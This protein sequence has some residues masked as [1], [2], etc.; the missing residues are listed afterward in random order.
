M[1]PAL[2]LFGLIL[3]TAPQPAAAFGDDGH[4]AVALIAEHYLTREARAQVSALLKAD[5]DPLT[6]HD[7]AS[8]ATWADKYRDSNNRRDHYNETR[9]WHFVDLEI[10]DPDLDT[11]CNGRKPLP[12]RTP[13]SAGPANDCVIDKITQFAAELG[14]GGTDAGERLLALKFVLHLVGDLHQPLHAADNNDAGGNRVKVVVEGFEHKSRDALHGFFD[15]QFV[16]ALAR[17]PAALA[18]QLILKITPQQ[19]A[20]WKT[21]SVEDW[22]M[23]AFNVAFTDVYGDPPLS[24]DKVE[25]LDA[26]YVQRAKADVAMQLS[27]AGV[28]LAL[29]LNQV[30]GADAADVPVR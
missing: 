28:R 15:S 13:A 12:P 26:A 23:E 16:D 25:R 20:E 22:A 4:K 18:R 10:E 27:K 6:A 8:A 1:K 2:A 17:P 11:A 3:T 7:I 14:V 30:F 9:N 24:K 5:S 21:G 29:I 19:E